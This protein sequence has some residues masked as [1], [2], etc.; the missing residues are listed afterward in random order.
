M[1]DCVCLYA[2]YD[3]DAPTFYNERW[4]TVRTE[5]RCYECRRGV[6]PRDRAFVVT[7]KWEDR[8]ETYYF[9]V[10]CQ[11]IAASLYCSGERTFGTLW[12][13]VT[14]QLFP[15]GLSGACL[16]KLATVEGKQYLSERWW[17]WVNEH[18]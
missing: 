10:A 4:V 15:D 9:C 3:G 7:G 12:E 6:W 1:T 5:H 8:I 16:D 11:D 2:D 17:Q 14:D 18:N 13:D